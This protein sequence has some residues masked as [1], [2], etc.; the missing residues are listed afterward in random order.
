MGPG[1]QDVPNAVME[2][3]QETAPCCPPFQK[4]Y[5]L[6]EL[7]SL[8][9]CEVQIPPGPLHSEFTDQFALGQEPLGC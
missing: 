4:C 3:T 8:L 2:G 5:H 9:S 7:G 6:W 1:L